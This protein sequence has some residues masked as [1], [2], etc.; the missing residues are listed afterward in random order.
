MREVASSLGRMVEVDWQTIF[1]SFFSTIRVRIQCKDPTRIPRRRIF[2]FNQ[3]IY[4]ISF[5]PEGFDQVDNPDGGSPD[6]DGGVEELEN[7]D[8]DDLLDDEPRDNDP[9]VGEQ[10]GSQGAGHTSGGSQHQS[11][12]SAEGS[13][14]RRAL[15][16]SELM[17]GQN[18]GTLDCL[19][20]LQAMELNEGDD[21]D[22]E[23]QIEFDTAQ[24]T[25]DDDVTSQLPEEWVFDFQ[26]KKPSHNLLENSLGSST[27]DSGQSS[28][29]VQLSQDSS[30][31]NQNK[32]G[33]ETVVLSTQPSEDEVDKAKQSEEPIKKQTKRHQE[34]VGPVCRFEKEYQEY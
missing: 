27:N 7:D 29:P 21:D 6:H 18:T 4:P 8:D 5:K 28:Q 30:Q 32:P 25:L 17:P 16:F 23:D 20:L 10:N 34:S 26:V 24:V 33:E 1:N 3:Q 22:L 9:P 15:N 11:G 31:V 19:Q 12:I 14:V 2:V 13:S